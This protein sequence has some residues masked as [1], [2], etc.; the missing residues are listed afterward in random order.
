MKK[1]KKGVG[2]GGKG[3][4]ETKVLKWYGKIKEMEGNK[5]KGS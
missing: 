2:K 3:E 1:G 4:M 5:I